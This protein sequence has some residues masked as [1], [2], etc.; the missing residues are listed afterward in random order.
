LSLESVFKNLYQ[1]QKIE[2]KEEALTKE[3]EVSKE[4]VGKKKEEWT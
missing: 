2:I 4:I 3:R 1:Q